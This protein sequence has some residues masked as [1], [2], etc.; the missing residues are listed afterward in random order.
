M[1]LCP[2]SVEEQQKIPSRSSQVVELCDVLPTFLE[3]AGDTVPHDM[4][5]RS[6]YAV[7]SKNSVKS[8][9]KYLVMEHS[10]CYGEADD[11]VGITNGKQKYVYYF[12]DGRELFFDLEKDPHELHNAVEDKAYAK[13]LSSLKAALV[14]SLTER[15]DDFVKSGNLVVRKKRILYSPN[16]PDKNP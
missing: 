5:G 13:R 7:L 11:W 15:G 3:T 8:W 6:L 14:S 16:Y 4:D 10:R 12:Y 1:Q 2:K 9:R